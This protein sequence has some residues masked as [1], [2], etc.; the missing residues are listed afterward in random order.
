MVAGRRTIRWLDSERVMGTGGKQFWIR[1]LGSLGP[2][3][4]SGSR[5]GSCSF[6]QWHSRCQHK[7]SFLLSF[8]CLLLTKGTFT[9]VFKMTSHK[10][11]HTTFEIKVFL[12]FL[13]VDGRIRIRIRIRIRCRIRIRICTSQVS[14][15]RTVEAQKLTDPFSF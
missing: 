10:R 6:R 5:S 7:I 3:Y 2:D 15:V 9:T 14:T 1:I 4:E 13:L 12:N 11:S 8:F